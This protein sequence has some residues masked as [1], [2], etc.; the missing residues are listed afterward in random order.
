[1]TAHSFLPYAPKCTIGGIFFLPRENILPLG[2][3]TMQVFTKS[4]DPHLVFPLVPFQADPLSLVGVFIISDMKYF[5]E[6]KLQRSGYG[7]YLLITKKYDSKTYYYVRIMISLQKMCKL[8]NI[9]E[10]INHP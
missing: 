8:Q 5:G 1:M 6:L 9:T 2:K 10:K 3:V 7:S 4:G